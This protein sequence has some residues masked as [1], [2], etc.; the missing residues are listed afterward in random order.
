MVV[1]PAFVVAAAEPAGTGSASLYG[2]TLPTVADTAETTLPDRHSIEQDL[3]EILEKEAGDEG[4]REAVMLWLE[5]LLANPLNINRARLEELMEVPGLTGALAEGIVAWREENRPFGS[6]EEVTEVR[7]IGPATLEKIRPY[8]TVGTPS[9]LRRDYYL[10]PA[11]WVHNPRTEM[12]SRFRQSLD[13]ADGYRMPDSL[14]GYV[15]GP[16]RL[17]QRI[18]FR[19]DHLSA[20]LIRNKRPGEPHGGFAGPDDGPVHIS[21]EELGRLQMLVVGDYR[22]QFGQ[23]LILGGGSTFGKG[24]NVI[25]S[26]NRGGAGIRGHT[27]TMTTHSF[28]GLAATWGEELQATAFWSARPRTASEASPDTIRFPARTPYYRTRSERERRYNTRQRTLGTRVTQHFSIDEE[29]RTS[30]RIGFGGWH[31]RFDRPVQPGSEAWEADRPGGRDSWAISGDWRISR[32][33]GQLFGEAGRSGNGG[34][35]AVTGVELAAGRGTRMTLA[36][37]RYGERFQ[38]IFGDSFSEQSGTPHNEEGWYLG[39]QHRL[40]RQLR[41]RGY[42]DLFQF[43]GPRFLTRRPSHG[44][45]W[46]ISTDWQPAKG[47]EIMVHVRGK[48]RGEEFTTADR[49]GMETRRLAPE[50]RFTTRFQVSR[51]LEPDL[52]ARF[53]FERVEA[54]PAG[55]ESSYGW[56]AWGDLRVEPADALRLDLRLAH[57]RTQSFH[58][59]V[60][61]YENDLLYAFASTMLYSRGH[62]AYLLANY[63][64]ARRLQIWLKAGVTL[65]RDRDGSGT[66]PTFIPG[67]RR[68]D[69]GLQA[70]WVF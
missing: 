14:G 13:L 34:W 47:T 69:I 4:D 23:G 3:E 2:A 39:I 46:L 60:Y 12:I 32:G 62:R 1:F 36:W 37:R 58:S 67:N 21:L 10:N 54:K 68:S 17:Y 48:V 53:R 55:E 31:N 16:E 66:G 35:G 45:D 59:R 18:H 63:R 20:A 42:A 51:Q 19:S 56:M 27:S 50:S 30:G 65:F 52:R 25:R 9:E 7:G 43:P 64:P 61:M 26:V 49:Y 40:S 29:P 57:F 22:V 41:V 6:V 24:Q 70:R 33:A 28:R 8:L 5:E 38:A 44:F 11:A 15:G